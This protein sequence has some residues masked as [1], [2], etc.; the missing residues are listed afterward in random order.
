MS[1]KI[2]S[3]TYI[4]TSSTCNIILYFFFSFS[5]LFF[6]FFKTFLCMGLYSTSRCIINLSNVI[7]ARC[8][9]E[10]VVPLDQTGV[11]YQVQ[12]TSRL[13]TCYRATFRYRTSRMPDGE[14]FFS[15]ANDIGENLYLRALSGTLAVYVPR[16]CP[17]PNNVILEGTFLFEICRGSF[18]WSFLAPRFP[19]QYFVALWPSL[20]RVSPRN[21]LL[22]RV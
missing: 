12:G 21:M 3:P 9:G 22:V 7:V 17:H 2:Y 11:T 19:L 4:H 8:C 15:N 10:R 5:F 13:I 18:F 1:N 14:F 20:N 16:F 6:N